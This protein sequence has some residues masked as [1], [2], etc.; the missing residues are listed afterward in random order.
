MTSN[1]WCYQATI[2]ETFVSVIKHTKHIRRNLKKTQQGKASS[3]QHCN[4]VMHCHQFTLAGLS[5][6]RF[7]TSD[8]HAASCEPSDLIWCSQALVCCLDPILSRQRFQA[9]RWHLH[10]S[11]H[12]WLWHAKIVDIFLHCNSLLLITLLLVSHSKIFMYKEIFDKLIR[13]HFASLLC[14]YVGM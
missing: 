1:I 10:L 6:L 5:P 13:W 12:I 8:H 4:N 14:R 9:Q 3:S 2:F 7:T 11:L